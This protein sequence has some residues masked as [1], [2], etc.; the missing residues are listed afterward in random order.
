MRQVLSLVAAAIAF[1]PAAALAQTAAPT[2]T[3]A[4]SFHAILDRAF[5]TG[6]WRETSGYRSQAREDEL[7]REGAGTVP[8]GQISHHSMGSEG[9]PGAYDVVV[10]G[11]S[12]AS[13]AQRLRGSQGINRVVAERAHG[14]EGPHLHIEPAAFGHGGALAEP[15]RSSG[16]DIYLRV[17]NGHRNPLLSRAAHRVVIVD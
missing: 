14:R 5:G 16:D 17:V 15:A 11:M 2:P 6:G 1:L 8:A 7:R 3:S 10:P 12:F 4:E 9:A 13:A